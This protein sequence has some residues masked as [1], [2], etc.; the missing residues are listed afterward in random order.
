MRCEPWGVT[1]E[2]DAVELLTLT[3]AAG[4]TASIATYGA[5]LVRL[6]HCPRSGT[7]AVD[8]VL[9]FDDLA[10]Y[11]SP[12]PYLGATVGRFA[13]RIA[14]G[15]LV[16]DGVRHSLTRNDG[17]HSLHGGSVGF[18]RAVWRVADARDDAV[19][20]CHVSPDGDQGYPGTLTCTVRYELTDADVLR[21]AYDATTDRRTV[22][23][24]TNHAY[25]NLGGASGRGI[26]GHRLSLDADRFIPVG[27][28]LIPTGEIRTVEGSPFD[29]RQP[30]IIGERLRG[31]NEQLQNAGGLD[32]CFVID[33]G[34][35][36]LRRAAVLGDPTTGRCLEVH[37]TSP[38]L[39]LYTGNM[40][41][42]TLRGRDGITYGRHHAL[43]LETQRFPDAPNQPA[44]PSAVLEPGDRFTALTEY[45][46]L[47][48]DR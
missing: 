5:T 37:T 38:G 24:L 3:N 16:L 28:D 35:G 10:G 18:D 8:I 23:N 1:A 33:G 25:F 4:T 31:S 27:A 14:N 44:F 6:L 9:G 13:N 20:L 41:D 26:L 15:E 39:Q 34:E 22:V 19:E 42:G 21:I 43:C 17:A 30:A 45:R 11:L 7:S 2:G 47:G 48:G 12:H 36:T 29:F 46:L 40:L 32:H